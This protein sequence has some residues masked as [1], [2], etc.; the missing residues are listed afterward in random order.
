MAFARFLICD[1]SSCCETTRPLGMC[2]M[3]TAEYVV[4]TDCPPGPDEP[5]VLLKLGEWSY[6]IYIGQTAWLQFIRLAERFYPSDGTMILGYRFG[7]LIWW[8]EPFA[9]LAICIVWGWLLCTYIESPAN[10]ALRRF[11]AR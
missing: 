5:C 2:V 1:F 7:D 4:L 10:R 11:F 8:P 9:L 3:R 6:A